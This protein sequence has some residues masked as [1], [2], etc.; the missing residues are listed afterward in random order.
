M[1]FKYISRIAICDIVCDDIVAT[2]SGQISATSKTT[3]LSA[4]YQ[5]QT[6]DNPTISE[7][8]VPP[9]PAQTAPPLITK[10]E[11]FLTRNFRDHA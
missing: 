8:R 6:I 9:I 5:A 10:T 3:F 2:Y 4:F 7:Q 1:F 11:V